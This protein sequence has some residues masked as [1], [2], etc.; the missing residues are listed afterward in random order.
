LQSTPG[1]KIIETRFAPGQN[2]TLTFENGDVFIIKAAEETGF[3]SYQVA[4][5]TKY[6]VV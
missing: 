3:E 2:L 6:F 1:Y 5:G 4:Y